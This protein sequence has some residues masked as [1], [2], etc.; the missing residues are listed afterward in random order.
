MIDSK[1][2]SDARMGALR[3][4]DT[5]VRVLGGCSGLLSYTDEVN[6]EEDSRV[7]NEKS[8]IGKE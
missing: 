7:K 8:G 5:A 2:M 4:R 6:R 3:Q 1:L